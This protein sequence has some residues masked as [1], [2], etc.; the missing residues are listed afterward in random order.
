[1]AQRIRERLDRL[2]RTLVA[3]RKIIEAALAQTSS[4]EDAVR[5]LE[6]LADKES[7]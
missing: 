3:L 1:V 6:A 4:P 2:S 5:Y 7:G